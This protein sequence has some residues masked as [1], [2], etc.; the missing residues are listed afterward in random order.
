ML[1]KAFVVLG[2]YGTDE[3]KQEL[4]SLD[5]FDKP[6]FIV[7]RR[8]VPH[9]HMLPPIAGICR[10]LKAAG[11]EVFPVVIDRGD[12]YLV[13]S[14]LR[15]GHVDSVE[16]ARSNIEQAR[17]HIT[18]QLSEVGLSPVRVNYGEFVRA[19]SVRKIFFGRF[20]LPEPEMEFF[21][22]NDFYEDLLKGNK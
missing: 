21:D 15:R 3:H 22:G 4:D 7:F 5:F 2:A 8:S 16:N 19:E 1:T 6:D 9:S 12:K 17:V 14:Q 18:L 13:F 11:Y 20:G 10:M